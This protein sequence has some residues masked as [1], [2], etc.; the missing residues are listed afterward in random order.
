ML[1]TVPAQRSIWAEHIAKKQAVELKKE[2]KSD[3]EIAKELEETIAGV[4][5]NDELASGMTTFFKDKDGYFVRDYFIK[6]FAKEAA[7]IKKDHGALK[8]LRSKVVQHLFVRPSKIYV[9]AANA[10]LEIIERPLRASTPQ[11]ER[12]AIARSHCVPAGTKLSFEVH[13]LQ[14]VIKKDL[15]ET[16]FE[17]GSYS[18][19]GQWRG[20]GHGAFNVLKLKEKK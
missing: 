14:D 17:Y 18:G 20:S 13:V 11:G 7:R 1:G 3:E 15:L 6:G 2:G 9:A 16:L 12:T 4:A 19:M 8:Q 10:E 5:D